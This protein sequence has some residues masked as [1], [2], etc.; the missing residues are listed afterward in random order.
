MIILFNIPHLS[1][2]NILRMY[3]TIPLTDHLDKA[4]C[5]S[6]LAVDLVNGQVPFS[7]TV[8][9]RLA[10]HN[11]ATNRKALPPYYPPGVDSVTHSE[12]AW[13]AIFTFYL[14]Q[15]QC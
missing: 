10:A 1:L 15:P 14:A 3:D 4:L 8:R 6:S 2:K 13:L 11:V 5:Y 9:V 7:A 12:H